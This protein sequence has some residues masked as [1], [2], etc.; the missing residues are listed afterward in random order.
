[1]TKVKFKKLELSDHE[2]V[3]TYHNKRQSFDVPSLIQFAKDKKYIPFIMPL[4]AVDMSKLMWRIESMTDIAIHF[5]RVMKTDISI[6][7]II[8]DC[9]CI[10]DGWHRVMKAIIRGKEQIPAIRL[11]EMPYPSKEEDI[12]S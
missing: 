8:D 12:E 2:Y 1:M 7:I 10:C 4:A 5:D 11:L 6:P 9:G 3:R